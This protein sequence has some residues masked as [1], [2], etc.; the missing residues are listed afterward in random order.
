[1]HSLNIE[2][3]YEFEYSRIYS[4]LLGEHL[5]IDFAANTQPVVMSLCG[6][7]AIVRAQCCTFKKLAPNQQIALICVSH[8]GK[9]SAFQFSFSWVFFFFATSQIAV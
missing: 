2:N 4:K 7:N 9:S 1:M 3:V 5:D 6:N 8:L